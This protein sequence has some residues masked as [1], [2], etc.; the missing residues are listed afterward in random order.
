VTGEFPH[1]DAEDYANGVKNGTTDFG[2]IDETLRRIH[3]ASSGMKAASVL[4]LQKRAAAIEVDGR[5]LSARQWSNRRHDKGEPPDRS[6]VP[7]TCQVWPTQKGSSSFSRSV[8]SA[9]RAN[10]P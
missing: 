9:R 8:F 3:V 4:G 2:P 6:V 7:Q 5:G 1:R 10:Y